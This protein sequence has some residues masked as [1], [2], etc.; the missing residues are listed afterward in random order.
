M[1]Q[2]AEAAPTSGVDG[3]LEEYS[4]LPGVEVWIRG[5]G[6]IVLWLLL[7]KLL[8]KLRVKTASI[9]CP[10]FLRTK[11]MFSSTISISTYQIDNYY[12][13]SMLAS[14]PGL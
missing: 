3:F 8:R 6:S 4:V 1:V 2:K 14:S 11:R 12:F 7:Y 13:H 9:Y 10:V 5:D